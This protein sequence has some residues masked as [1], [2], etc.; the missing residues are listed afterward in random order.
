[1]PIDP[2]PEIKSIIGDLIMQLAVLQ[3]KVRLLEQDNAAMKAKLSE[4]DI[5][6]V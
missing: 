6:S 3:A 2:T 4:G 5:G 1:M